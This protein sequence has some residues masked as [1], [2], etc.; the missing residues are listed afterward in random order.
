MFATLFLAL[1][2]LSWFFHT[3]TFLLRAGYF[4]QYFSFFLPFSLSLSCLDVE[5]WC[6]FIVHDFKPT[7]LTRVTRAYHKTRECTESDEQPRSEFM[8]AKNIFGGNRSFVIWDEEL[9]TFLRS[10]HDEISIPISSFLIISRCGYFTSM[11][12]YIYI[13]QSIRSKWNSSIRVKSTRKKWKIL[14]PKS[15]NFIDS[16]RYPNRLQR[17]RLKALKAI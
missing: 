1:I 8:R 15:K 2:D 17:Y 12:L 9:R 5:I 7:R 6:I 11:I 4:H 10:I 13:W 14:P 3:Q 16:S